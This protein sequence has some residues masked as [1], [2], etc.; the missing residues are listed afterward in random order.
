M[1]LLEANPAGRAAEAALVAAAR[2]Q[3][4][5][6]GAYEPSP[7]I[8]PRK[9]QMKLNSAALRDEKVGSPRLDSELSDLELAQLIENQMAD[10][11]WNAIGS[12]WLIP[13]RFIWSS[14]TDT[15]HV[16]SQTF[17]SFFWLITE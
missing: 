1:F 8:S 11:H 12:V 7:G 15:F 16:T 6:T 2:L 4:N 5:G 13:L 14:S 3:L 10:T 9:H 17:S